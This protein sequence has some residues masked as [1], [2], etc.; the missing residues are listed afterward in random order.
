MPEPSDRAAWSR[1]L[2]AAARLVPPDRLE[3]VAERLAARPEVAERVL[4]GERLE[5][6]VA[7][8]DG[9]AL[10]RLAGALAGALR[11]L[12]GDDDAVAALVA[13]VAGVIGFEQWERAGWHLT[14]NRLDSPI[15][16][17]RQ[18]AAK[19]PSRLPGVERREDAQLALLAEAVASFGPE[20]AALPLRFDGPGRF[21]LDNQRFGPVDAE[22]ALAL[23]RRERP[24]LLVA[25]GAGWSTLLADE[26]MAANAAGGGPEGRIVVLEPWPGGFL[27]D[28]AAASP[29]IELR[30]EPVWAAG[31]ATFEAL[32][33]GDMLWIDSSHVSRAGSDVNFLLLEVLPRLA[34]GVLVHL[35][36]IW[37]PEAYPP[38]WLSG[39]A[40]RRR[41]WNEQYL[42][43]A[44]MAFNAGYELVWS[45]RLV[46]AA[47]PGA[48]AAA[49]P[50][51]AHLAA[52]PSSLWLRRTGAQAPG[53]QG[54]W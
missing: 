23:V 49:L 42:V 51:L 9:P 34:P 22:L 45:S 20:L 38:E 16:D 5:A 50:S 17:T 29:R 26:A 31:A 46:Q 52:D 24:R 41:F 13:G 12:A 36:G 44:F 15:P 28:A 19:E 30:E 2:R 11:G 3:Q 8:L 10:T 25:A 43:Q 40:G 14:P 6:E 35:Q 54:S 39:E 48:L 53:A 18:V 1:G 37:L 21:F 4:R 33:A 7:R 27:R 32:G 47:H